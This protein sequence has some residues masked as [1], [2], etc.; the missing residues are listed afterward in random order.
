MLLAIGSRFI[1][2]GRPTEGDVRNY[3]WFHSPRYSHFGVAGWQRR[4]ARALR[5]LENALANPWH[6]LVRRPLDRERYSVMMILAVSE[7]GSLVDE[8]FADC[9]ADTGMPGAPIATMEAQLIHRF[10]M[11]YRWEPERTRH[12][13]LKQLFQLTRCIRANNGEDVRDQ[14]E[15]KILEA[16]LQRRLADIQAKSAKE[17]AS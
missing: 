8:A 15:I 5:P 4:K 2:G 12:T 11:D 3:L 9:P 14:G 6:R 7:I 16:H 10:A 17:A 1:C 13:P